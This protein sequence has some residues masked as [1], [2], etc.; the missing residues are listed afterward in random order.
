[1]SNPM[2]P[3]R[4]NALKLMAA[5]LAGMATHPATAA[6]H[7][8]TDLFPRPATGEQSLA[9]LKEG[10]QRDLAQSLTSC[11]ADIAALRDHSEAHQEPFAAILSCADSRVPVELLFDQPL[12]HLFVVRVAGNIATPDTIASLEYAGAAVGVNLILVIGHTSCGAIKAASANKPVPGQVST[13]FQYMHPA[14]AGTADLTEASRRNA[15][16]QAATLSNASPVL[17]DLIATRKLLIKAAIY[18]VGSGKV[19]VLEG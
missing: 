15:L 18:D 11:T 13:L 3:N 10:H 19:T 14:V 4:R 8:P 17:A 7:E 9:L 6:V 12:G 2:H 5:G 16:Q 1:M